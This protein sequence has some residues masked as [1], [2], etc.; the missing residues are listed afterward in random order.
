MNIQCGVRVQK[1]VGEHG[2]CN[3]ERFRRHLADHHHTKYYAIFHPILLFGKEVKICR[4]TYRK[5][6]NCRMNSVRLSLFD[7]TTCLLKMSSTSM[8]T[9]RSGNSG[10]LFKASLVTANRDDKFDLEKFRKSK[11]QLSGNFDIKILRFQNENMLNF[12]I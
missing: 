3:I 9:L 11:E 6:S 8:G 12:I 5:S 2:A 1:R 4:Q 10:K 7:C